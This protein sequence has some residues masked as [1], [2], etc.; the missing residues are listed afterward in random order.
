MVRRFGRRQADMK[1]A[2]KPGME[3]LAWRNLV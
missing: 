2:E 1:G 3:K